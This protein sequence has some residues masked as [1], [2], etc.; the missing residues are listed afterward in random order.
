MATRSGDP[1]DHEPSTT[2]C[3]DCARPRSPTAGRLS[4]R[5][6]MPLIIV[7]GS[8]AEIR[9]ACDPAGRLGLCNFLKSPQTFVY[10]CVH[11][12][13][14][15]RTISQNFQVLWSRNVEENK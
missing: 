15:L 5:L 13:L 8:V 3:C 4:I 1:R 9:V 14:T 2:D 6:E 11:M 10:M 12:I 7:E